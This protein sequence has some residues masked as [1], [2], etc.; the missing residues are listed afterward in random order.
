M[1]VVIPKTLYMGVVPSQYNPQ[2]K[3]PKL[4]N[5]F[6]TYNSLSNVHKNA[7]IKC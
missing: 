7:K 6:K 3:M 4:V 5:E 1:V 2:N